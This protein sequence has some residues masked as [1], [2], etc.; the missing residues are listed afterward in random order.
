MTTLPRLKASD[1]G[2]FI[3]TETGD[4]FFWLGDTAWDLL[5]RCTLEEVRHYFGTRQRQGFNVILTVALAEPDGVRTTNHDGNLPLHD[6]DP[7]RPNDTYFA[8]IDTVIAEAKAHSLYIALLPTWGDKVNNMQ[9]A[10]D[11]KSST[12]RMPVFMGNFSV[13]VT[14][15]NRM[16][17]GCWL[18]ISM[19][20][21]AICHPTPAR[22]MWLTRTRLALKW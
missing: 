1:N 3:V 11:R 21:S 10:T 13:S 14:V 8:F 9:W 20:L 12:G 5:H 18:L 15:S 16:W 17:S 22:F 6:L 4:P 7:T 2:R 19:I